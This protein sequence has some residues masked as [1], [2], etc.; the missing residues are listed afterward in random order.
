MLGF[1]QTKTSESIKK[2]SHW[3]KSA[4]VSSAFDKGEKV[5]M[6]FPKESVRLPR[7][8]WT[9]LQVVELASTKE[10]ILY[11]YGDVSAVRQGGLK[12]GRKQIDRWRK[13]GIGYAC[14]GA[15]V[16]DALLWSH[17]TWIPWFEELY[18]SE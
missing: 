8:N 4:I 5:L 14:R 7:C 12:K 17:V 18:H 11:V 15:N 6:K 2:S 13:R 9:K 10:R 16:F 1:K 3:R